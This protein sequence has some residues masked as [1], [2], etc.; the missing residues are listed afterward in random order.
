MLRRA[1][2][3]ISHH[4]DNINEYLNDIVETDDDGHP[5]LNQVKCECCGLEEDCTQNY[6]TKIRD[7]YS[8][9]WVCGLCSE[10]MK[11]TSERAPGGRTTV[12]QAMSSHRAVCQE[13]NSNRL[14][15][16]LSLTCAM[17]KLAKRVSEKRV[18]S[19]VIPPFS[20]LARASSC[21]PKIDL[22]SPAQ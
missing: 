15:P 1:I 18:G 14:N 11:E 7:S 8:G 20:R 19:V 22:N 17:K 13:F 12:D 4:I 10:V 3:D 6:I 9:K 16:K 5:S 21:V 2:S